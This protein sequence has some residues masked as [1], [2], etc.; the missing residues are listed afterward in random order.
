MIS[1][2]YDPSTWE[3]KEENN[4]ITLKT[5]GNNVMIKW[6]MVKK[7]IKKRKKEKENVVENIGWNI[8]KQIRKKK[9][10]SEI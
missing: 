7:Y 8:G 10:E 1:S 9:L 6:G 2:V 3:I 5:F 4:E